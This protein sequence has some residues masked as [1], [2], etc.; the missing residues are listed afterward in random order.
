MD[1]K[2]SHSCSRLFGSRASFKHFSPC[3]E[4]PWCPVLHVFSSYISGLLLCPR[5][6]L[7]QSNTLWERR[8]KFFLLPPENYGLSTNVSKFFQF[9]LKKSACRRQQPDNKTVLSSALCKVP[10]YKLL[11]PYIYIYIYTYVQIAL[12]AA[13]RSARV[14]PARASTADWLTVGFPACDLSD[15]LTFGSSRYRALPGPSRRVSPLAALLPPSFFPL[16]AR[17][18][19]QQQQ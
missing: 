5:K 6:T 11:L 10:H 7:R 14:W 19:Q 18:R 15:W 2:G 17:H 13:T 12:T 9:L 3:L 16:R 4:V 8:A 1:V